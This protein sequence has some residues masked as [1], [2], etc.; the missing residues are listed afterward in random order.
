MSGVSAS[1][2]AHALAD[3]APRPYWL[4]QPARPDVLPG[5]TGSVS[6]DLLVI[7]GGYTGLWAALLAK[8]ADPS[9]S[10]VLVEAGTCG[11]AA[12]GRNGGFCAASITH[13]LANGIARFPREIATLE[14]LGRDNLAAIEAADYSFDLDCHFERTG[15]LD[16]AVAPYQVDE[17]RESVTV[18]KEYGAD[19]VFLDGAS[20]R[21]EVDS[22][23]YLA[24][25]WNR[26]GMAMV[27]PARL[28]WGLRRACLALGVSIYE[29]T[30]VV[31]LERSGPRIRAAAFGGVVTADRVVLAT[32]AF[33]PLLR[34]LRHFL[35]PVY[36]YA[37]MTQPLSNEQ[38]ASIGWLNRQGLGDTAN[39][40]HYYRLSH[41]NRILFGGYDAIYHFG[42]RINPSLEQR[43]AT[44][45]LLA[46]HFY[47][48]FPQLE[49]VRF[50]HKWA[51]VIDT[52]TRFCAFWG[53]AFD[54]SVS[55]VAGYTGLGVGASRF[56]AKVALDLVDGA[57][58]E[59]TSLE[60]V[61]RKPVPFPPE[62]LRYAGVQL[63][64]WSLAQADRHDGR[65]NLWLRAMDAAGLGFDS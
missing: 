45:S 26:D 38:I 61:R 50:T 17:L 53:R 63:T 28:A 60:F 8:S 42:G 20:V 41:D 51:G 27:D 52:C 2:I 1:L 59:E 7:G 32:N 58:S 25:A 14:R 30:H 11:W 9:R 37:L 19:I 48:T 15:A 34:R 65:R 36:D 46:R 40:F 62:P 39:Q 56:G 4:D 29:H 33:P 24:G 49:S 5:L 16:V 6:A 55:Y 13:G 44:F 12:S 10:V 31:S 22:P 18:A 43:P 64:R 3:A 54:G 21:A 35:V 47:Q 23:T 57:E